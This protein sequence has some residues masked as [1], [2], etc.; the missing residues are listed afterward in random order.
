MQNHLKKFAF[1]LA[2]ALGLSTNLD[3]Y[4]AT[5]PTG[6]ATVSVTPSTLSEN[7]IQLYYGS[8]EDLLLERNE[9]LLSNASFTNQSTIW[10]SM[11]PAASKNVYSMQYK[12]NGERLKTTLTPPYSTSLSAIEMYNG[13]G[14]LEVIA[15]DTSSVPIWS[16][17]IDVQLKGTEPL[18]RS[19]RSLGFFP[20]GQ[21]PIYS[22]TYIPVLLYHVFSEE[23]K[24]SQQ[25]IAVDIK[26]FEEQL[27]GLL[28]AGY[29]P[30]S[31]Y[32]L[33][34]YLK[35][36][37]GL[38]QKPFLV[39][40]DDG[41]LNNYTLAYPILKKYN[42][43]ATFFLPPASIAKN[44]GLPRFNW[45]QALEMEQSGLI[46]IQIHG[47]DHTPFNKLSL[48]DVSYQVLR[49][50]GVIE[51]KLGKRDILVVSCPEF[52]YTPETQAL[53]K[54]MNVSFQTTNTATPEAVFKRED[55]KRIIVPN[56]MTSQELIN[57][58]E[59]LT[60]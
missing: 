9:P 14:R 46:D 26:H 30:I 43:P 44:N 11:T 49:A 2:T 22:S 53:L 31:F 56:Y 15:Y 19:K 60:Q 33:D 54:G 45:E 39:T 34:R 17:E 18:P 28:E 35:G 57:T 58:I 21:K 27:T 24:P 3:L 59:L 52:R 29:T 55:I 10:V 12:L 4:A 41:Y 32:D 8:E 25:Y 6:E 5:Y 51:Q 20:L 13:L 48:E 38:P 7:E 36:K 23:V 37:S 42:V 1:I 50:I 47:Y 40:S 16:K